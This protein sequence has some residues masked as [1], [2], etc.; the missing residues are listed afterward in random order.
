[1]NL[2]ANTLLGPKQEVGSAVWEAWLGEQVNTEP[3]NVS[4]L[5]LLS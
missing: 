2:L 4:G 3:H 5:P 1:M